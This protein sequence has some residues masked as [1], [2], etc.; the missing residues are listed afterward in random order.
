MATI[1]AATV[2]DVSDAEN[3]FL[4]LAQMQ[5]TARAPAGKGL[6]GT[7]LRVSG[8]VDKY[9]RFLISCTCALRIMCAA[10]N[11][12]S[13]WLRLFP[14]VSYLLFPGEDPCLLST[15]GKRWQGVSPPVKQERHTK[16]GH[17]GSIPIEIKME[18]C[19]RCFR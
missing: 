13:N 7:G 12:L 14:V 9:G 10:Q 8:K 2:R 18:F 6:T 11:K 16:A 1:A 15:I 17:V 3:G 19:Y 5:N 4:R